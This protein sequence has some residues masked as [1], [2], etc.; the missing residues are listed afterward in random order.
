VIPAEFQPPILAAVTV[1][2]MFHLDS[3]IAVYDDDG[4]WKAFSDAVWSE[5][6]WFQKLLAIGSVWMVYTVAFAVVIGL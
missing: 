1:F 5:A 6:T 2:A 4:Y 3:Y